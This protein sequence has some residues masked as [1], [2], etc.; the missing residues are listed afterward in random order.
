M[1]SMG[2]LL[3]K[4]L[5]ADSTA[6]IVGFFQLKLSVSITPITP[7]HGGGGSVPNTFVPISYPDDAP[8]VD[9]FKNI[10]ITVKFDNKSFVS[11]QYT[12]PTERAYSISVTINRIN[13]LLS[14]IQLN[15]I[16]T[17]TATLIRNIKTTLIKQSDDK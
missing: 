8:D 14:S 9:K 10:T 5:G 4:G 17:V 15:H 7:P 1:D 13:R 3:T 2:G 16:K 12:V 11:R 6:L